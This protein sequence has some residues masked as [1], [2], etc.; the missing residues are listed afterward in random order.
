MRYFFGLLIAG[1]IGIF[2]GYLALVYGAAVQIE[3]GKLSRAYA[4]AALL[5]SYGAFACWMARDLK[6]AYEINLQHI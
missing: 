3:C 4:W 2:I 5:N 6:E 1:I